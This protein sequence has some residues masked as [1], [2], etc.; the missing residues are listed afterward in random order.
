MDPEIPTES[1][2]SVPKCM[3]GAWHLW[4]KILSFFTGI[5][6]SV[7]G[8]GFEGNVTSGNSKILSKNDSTAYGRRMQNWNRNIS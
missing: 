4:E 1:I 8:T 7:W 2:Q 6:I 5:L 3:G